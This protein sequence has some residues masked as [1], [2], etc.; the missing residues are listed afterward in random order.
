MFIHLYLFIE[1]LNITLIV[2]GQESKILNNVPIFSVRNTRIGHS[3]VIVVIPDNCP[4]PKRRIFDNIAEFKR[5]V[6]NE[7]FNI[8]GNTAIVSF[9]DKDNLRKFVMWCGVQGYNR[10]GNGFIY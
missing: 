7:P 10:K 4:I 3:F 5:D 2:N 6:D 1:V 8:N 9:S